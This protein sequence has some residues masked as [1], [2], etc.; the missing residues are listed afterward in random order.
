MKI[1]EI[2]KLSKYYETKYKIRK[3]ARCGH[4]TTINP[5]WVENTGVDGMKIKHVFDGVYILV[6]PGVILDKKKLREAVRYS[7]SQSKEEEHEGG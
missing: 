5:L 7:P 1:Q 2:R 3:A 6:P 4:E